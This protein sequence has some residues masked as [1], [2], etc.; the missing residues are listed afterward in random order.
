K[1][2]Y[3]LYLIPIILVIVGSTT[4]YAQTTIGGKVSDAVSG[5]PL[6]GVNII[7]KGKVVGTISNVNGEF[8]LRVNDSPPL[9]LIF[10]FVG[11]A[12]QEVEITDAN[13]TNL[14]IKMS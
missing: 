3:K 5:D 6:A 9:T 11:Y 12:S 1:K 8:N 7:V 2:L 10:S 13:A 14:D 4:A